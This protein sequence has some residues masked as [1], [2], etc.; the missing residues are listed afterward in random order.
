MFKVNLSTCRVIFNT[1]KQSGR[2]GKKSTRK[3]KLRIATVVNFTILNPLNRQPSE[4][5]PFVSNSEVYKTFYKYQIFVEKKD[6]ARSCSGQLATILKQNLQDSLNTTIKVLHQTA[7]QK[8][9]PIGMGILNQTNR[10]C[11][12][13]QAKLDCEF[14]K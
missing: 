1:Y 4:S 3:T 9:T 2:I 12:T 14:Q 11:S 8:H 13:I 7:L 5:L 10:A 6:W